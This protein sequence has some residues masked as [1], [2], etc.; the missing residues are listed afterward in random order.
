MG[1]ATGCPNAME[2]ELGGAAEEAKLSAGAEINPAQTANA[3]PN[4]L[5]MTNSLL[6]ATAPL[7]GKQGLRKGGRIA[8]HFSGLARAAAAMSPGHTGDFP[9][10]RRTRRR[11]YG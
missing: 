4:A 7:I 5:A 9:G 3:T 2:V 10:P 1:M 6:H 8:S 11:P